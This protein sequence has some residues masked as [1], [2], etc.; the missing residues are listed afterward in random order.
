MRE[1]D[2]FS[3]CQLRYAGYLLWFV[4]VPIVFTLVH[5]GHQFLPSVLMALSS[6]N[7]LSAISASSELDSVILAR[8]RLRGKTPGLIREYCNRWKQQAN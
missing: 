1:F 2:S 3:P 4:L 8:K 5:F 6:V 7:P